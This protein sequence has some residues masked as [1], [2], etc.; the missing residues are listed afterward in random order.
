MSDT[1]SCLTSG[2]ALRPKPEGVTRRDKDLP[3]PTPSSVPPEG[4]T[5]SSPAPRHANTSPPSKDAPNPIGRDESRRALRRRS[6]EVV[7]EA[8]G[9]VHAFMEELEQ[10]RRQLDEQI[11]KYISQKER[12]YKLYERDLRTKYRSPGEARTTAEDAA[13][14]T[15]M[16]TTSQTTAQKDLTKRADPPKETEAENVDQGSSSAKSERLAAISGL[17]DTR[18]SSEREKEFLGLFTP[19]F[20]P[21]L[22]GKSPELDRSPSAPLLSEGSVTLVLEPDRRALHRANTDPLFNAG[23][24]KRLER[25]GLTQRTPSSGS[26]AG[27]PLVSAL[28]SSNTG[29]NHPKRKRVSIKLEVG[30]EVE[31]VHPSD[32]VP[33]M[34][35][36]TSM[37]HSEGGHRQAQAQKPVEE[38]SQAEALSVQ[39]PEPIAE[40]YPAPFTPRKQSGLTLGLMSHPD[41]TVD[42]PTNSDSS[43]TE[44]ASPFAMDEEMGGARTGMPGMDSDEG[45]LELDLDPSPGLSPRNEFP[46]L[47]PTLTGSP[48]SNQALSLEQSDNVEVPIGS[49]RSPSSFAQPTSPG[50]SRPAATKDPEYF[51]SE[52]QKV[53]SPPKGS[54][55]GSFTRPNTARQ[56]SSSLG[57]SYMQRN[58]A[59]LM[60]RRQSDENK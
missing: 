5:N 21:L 35:N 39:A 1:T 17:E 4:P 3:S 53:E 19:A 31:V 27:R 15:E 37:H 18:P 36:H 26:D 57:E 55:Y 33:K 16:Q 42:I 48:D 13:G 45:D 25:L 50:F 20:L 56:A 59:T 30:Q 58:A 60:R 43:K 6:V 54:Y 11:H 8:K 23:E 10:K 44:V 49:F 51:F 7:A 47:S 12:E 2:P 22:D 9:N 29:P 38:Q 34:G 32:S 41:R 14:S 28:K 52:E 40:S 46:E 24:V